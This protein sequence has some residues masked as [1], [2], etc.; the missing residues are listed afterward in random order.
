M[1]IESNLQ[2]RS[3]KLCLYPD[4]NNSRT[5]LQ[6]GRSIDWKVS[7]SLLL[8]LS[9]KM[10][11][12]AKRSSSRSRICV[13]TVKRKHLYKYCEIFHICIHHRRKHKCKDCKGSQIC[14]HNRREHQC[15]SASSR[16]SSSSKYLTRN[17]TCRF[18]IRCGMPV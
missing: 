18:L 3:P 15:K 14:I 16:E 8:S 6:L 10:M 13:C 9:L 11:H 1:P 17:Q 7:T 4:S 2:K 12:C 5:L